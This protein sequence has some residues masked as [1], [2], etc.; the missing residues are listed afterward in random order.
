MATGEVA[1]ALAEVGIGDV[2]GLMSK[3][4]RLAVADVANEL[5]RMGKGFTPGKLYGCLLREGERI[6]AA[7][8]KRAG[9]SEGVE[10]ARQEREAEDR[11]RDPER[12]DYAARL[13]TD[14]ANAAPVDAMRAAWHAADPFACPVLLWFMVDQYLANQAMAKR[15]KGER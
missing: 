9:T 7:R 2:T 12:A 4:P 3:R 15:P 6:I 5:R 14:V 1:D 10:R 13:K 11:L 8:E